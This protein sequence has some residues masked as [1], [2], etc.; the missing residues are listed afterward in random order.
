MIV[1]F[2]TVVRTAPVHDGGEIVK[3]DWYQKKILDR[4]PIFASDPAITDPNPRGGTRGGRGIVASSDS[5]YVASYHSI[6]KLDSQLQSQGRISNNNF[7][8]I[9][10][11]CWEDDDIW[12]TSTVLDALLKVDQSGNVIDEWWPREDS[13]LRARFLLEHLSLDKSCDN[14]LAYLGKSHVQPGHTHLNAVAMLDGRPIVLLN[15]LGVIVRLRP[16]EILVEDACLIGA[17]NVVVTDNG[18]IIANDTRRQS[19]RIYD[20]YGKF[21]REIRLGCYPEVRKTRRRFWSRGLRIWLGERSPSFKVYWWLVKDIIA[22]RPIFLR[23]LCLTPHNTL[24]AGISPA[25]IMEVDWKSGR[26][27]DSFTYSSDV[28]NAIH[29]IVCV[30]GI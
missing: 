8:D 15:Q 28:N 17:H 11:L 13:V 5:L 27:V 23:G 26:L 6:N 22:S 2:S 21:V 16:T 7:A 19:I 9:H 12:V 14:R 30:P 20:S 29:G 3:L 18:Y 10:E 24:L 4:R 1:Y 25:T